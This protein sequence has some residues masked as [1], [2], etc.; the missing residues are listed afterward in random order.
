[1]N[2]SEREMAAFV[3]DSYL[4]V[5]MVSRCEARSVESWVTNFGLVMEA[6]TV[7]M[8]GGFFC[9]TIRGDLSKSRGGEK[10][11]DPWL[12]R[13]TWEEGHET[14]GDNMFGACFNYFRVDMRTKL[15]RRQGANGV[16]RAERFVSA[17]MDGER[18]RDPHQ[19]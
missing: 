11:N 16:R 7:A 13:C 3:R 19:A 17:T 8:N 12:I 1:M 14:A 15:R 9:F 2:S 18:D 10:K 5:T 4:D 6:V